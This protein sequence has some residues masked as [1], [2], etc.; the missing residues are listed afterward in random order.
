MV[1]LRA[2]DQLA[3]SGRRPSPQ[4]WQEQTWWE[5]ALVE[6]DVRNSADRTHVADI[7]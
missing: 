3:A 6:S 4:R 5:W 1:T 2:S 7:Q